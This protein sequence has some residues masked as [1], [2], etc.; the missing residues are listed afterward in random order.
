MK[1]LMILLLLVVAAF[2]PGCSDT[3]LTPE[4]GGTR[5]APGTGPDPA[6]KIT[7]EKTPISFVV[8][9]E[10]TG[11]P[12]T[13]EGTLHYQ[14]REA[15]PGS[16]GLNYAAIMT[17]QLKGV[18]ATSG[19]LYTYR[20]SQGFKYHVARNSVYKENAVSHLVSQGSSGNIY[21]RIH[22]N[23]VVTPAGGVVMSKAT[24]ETGCTG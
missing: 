17:I 2:A 12:V 10:C 6:A 8:D 18:G 3:P 13:L 7:N 19:R 11:E 16:G 1:T 14:E 9:N 4:D 5:A 15:D 21:L 23:M 22:F 20:F 24:V